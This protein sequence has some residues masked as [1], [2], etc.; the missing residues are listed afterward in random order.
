MPVQNKTKNLLYILFR[1]LPILKKYPFVLENKTTI[2]IKKK[3][4][5]EKRK[6]PG[7]SPSRPMTNFYTKEDMIL[8]PSFDITVQERDL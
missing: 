2:I 3:P 8:S 4:E 7:C 5:G 1:T 6:Q